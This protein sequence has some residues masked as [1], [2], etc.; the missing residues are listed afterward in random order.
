MHLSPDSTKIVSA[1]STHAA[2]CLNSCKFMSNVNTRKIYGLLNDALRSE[3]GSP[4]RCRP[5][6][7][8]LEP[9]PLLTSGSFV[10]LEIRALILSP[11]IRQEECVFVEN[12]IKVRIVRCMTRSTDGETTHWGL[13]LRACRAW[14]KICASKTRCTKEVTAF[15]YDTPFIR[16]LPAEDWR[17]IGPEN[18]NGGVSNL[19]QPSGELIVFRE[20][21][22]LKVFIHETMHAFGIGPTT[23][24]DRNMTAR[25]KDRFELDSE[26]EVGEAYI[27]TWARI[28]NVA[29][30]VYLSGF[31]TRSNFASIFPKALRTESLFATVQAKKMLAFMG[32]SLQMLTSPA[33]AAASRALYKENTNVFAYYVM[34]AALLRDPNAF[35]NWCEATN[36]NLVK[37][38][39]TPASAASFSTLVIDSLDSQELG[40]LYECI[41]NKLVKRRRLN[42]RFST[43]NTARMTAIELDWRNK[44]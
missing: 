10:P 36:S 29:F 27:E 43:R 4:L 30:S 6:T 34:T 9:S 33:H 7:T 28:M 35:Y 17:V 5:R 40:R 23:A 11:T 44:L 39:N 1:L 24:I 13:F 16:N 32:L 41:P 25:L 14:I 2:D 15:L 8:L 38:N 20:E 37:F 31:D 3:M 12:G 18:V 19:C 21:E 22:W 26:M 42:S